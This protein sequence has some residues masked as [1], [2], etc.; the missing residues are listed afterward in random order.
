MYVFMCL[1][2]YLIIMGY[3]TMPRAIDSIII[4]IYVIS[5]TNLKLIFIA[6]LD[7]YI[8]ATIN[9]LYLSIVYIFFFFNLLTFFLLSSFLLVFFFFFFSFFYTIFLIQSRNKKFFVVLKFRNW[10]SFSLSL[11]LT[12]WLSPFE[13]SLKVIK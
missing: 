2:I 7:G 4:F 11:S 13:R 9:K 3:L 12:F 5:Q 8:N 1:Y 6:K 10:I